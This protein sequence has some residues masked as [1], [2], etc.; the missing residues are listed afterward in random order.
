MLSTI[1]GDLD[2]RKV[3]C[4]KTSLCVRLYIYMLY[5]QSFPETLLLLNVILL[6]AR[7]L[8]IYFLLWAFANQ[9]TKLLIDTL[10]T[11]QMAQM[12]D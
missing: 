9:S 8:F 4:N 5:V 12:E 11:N 10:S 3:W 6:E 1:N 2:D 7:T